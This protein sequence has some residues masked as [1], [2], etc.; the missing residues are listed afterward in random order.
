MTEK[1][2][3][4]TQSEKSNITTNDS[5]KNS[6]NEEV[7]ITNQPTELSISEL[8]SEL[9]ETKQNLAEYE[10]K[11]KHSLA[12]FQNLQR[13]TQSDMENGINLKIDKL[14]LEFLTIYDDLFLAKK[15]L[16]DEKSDVSGLVSIVKNMN[17]L[18]LEYKVTPINAL[19]EIFNPN[20]H[21][22]VSV[23]EDS[24]LDDG[25]ITKEIRKGYIS[26]NRVIRPTI[27]EISKKLKLDNNLHGE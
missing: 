8:K 3:Q 17:S 26:H 19:G 5:D 27:V 14:L 11:L 12:D 10:E 1:D 2:Q 16:A 18:L 23:V 9:Q 15:V 25:T 20:F 7:V 22:A 21:E 4:D 6:V 24:S 13:K